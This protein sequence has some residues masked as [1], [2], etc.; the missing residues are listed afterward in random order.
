[1]HP[2]NWPPLDFVDITAI[3]S[4]DAQLQRKLLRCYSVED[5][6][7]IEKEHYATTRRDTECRD[8]IDLPGLWDESDT[9][10]SELDQ[11]FT[12]EWLVEIGFDHATFSGINNYRIGHLLYCE[13]VG[14]SYGWPIKISTR[15]DVLK[16]L[17]VL[18]IEVKR[19]GCSR[20]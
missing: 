11:P 15:R 19:C 17:E 13:T 4:R 1:M 12:G 8:V 16:W 7:A 5:A 2:I 14:W 9:L 6:E 20:K 10:I 18:G 3:V